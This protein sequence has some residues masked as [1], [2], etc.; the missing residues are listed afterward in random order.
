VHGTPYYLNLHSG[1]V[2]HT[3]LARRYGES[4]KSFT[5][6][7]SLQSAQKYDPLTFI[8]DLGGSYETLTRPSAGRI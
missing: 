6:F 5:D 1:D 2:A 7:V 3:L 8:F 4:G